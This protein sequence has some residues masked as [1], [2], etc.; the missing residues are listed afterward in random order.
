MIRLREE[1]LLRSRTY[2][3][4]RAT[5]D[6]QKTLNHAETALRER[7]IPGIKKAAFKAAF[8]EQDHLSNDEDGAD[9]RTR[10]STVLPTSTSS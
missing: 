7:R 2:A 9:E 5:D 1:T 3:R 6:G 8:F 10:T 4:T